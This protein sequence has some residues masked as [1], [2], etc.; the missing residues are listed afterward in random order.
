MA[1]VTLCVYPGMFRHVQDIDSSTVKIMH[2]Y[3]SL[4]VCRY[5]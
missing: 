3:V 5:L 4:A 1:S 2:C